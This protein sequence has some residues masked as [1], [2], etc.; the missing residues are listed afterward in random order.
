MRM[1][2][3]SV[4]DLDEYPGLMELLRM[5]NLLMPISMSVH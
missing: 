2:N 4:A 3:I 1:R 5:V